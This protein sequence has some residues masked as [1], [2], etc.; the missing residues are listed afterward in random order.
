VAL[1]P[2][3]LSRALLGAPDSAG[4]AGASLRNV[5]NAVAGQLLPVELTWDGGLA[6]SFD[7]QLARPGLAYQLGLGGT[8]AFR[9]IQDDTAASTIRRAGFQARSGLRLS[10]DAAIEVAY[11]HRDNTLAGANAVQSAQLDRT[12]PDVELRWQNI[13]IPHAIQP[14][15][16]SASAVAGYTLDRQSTTIG[17]GGQQVEQSLR[18]S[19]VPLQLRMRFGNGLSITYNSTLTSG[20]GSDPT[21]GTLQS[22]VSHS[23]S[24]GGRFVAPEALRDRFP[25]PIGLSV[26]YDYEAERQCRL[27]SVYQG[28]ED[29]TP[30]VDSL[31]RRLDVTLDS[32]VSQLD[33][34]IQLSYNDRRSFVGTRAGNSQFQLSVFGQFDF[35]AGT[36]AG[37]RPGGR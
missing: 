1:E 33:V 26:R 36:F 17:I 29:C 3:G 19:T 9:T 16:T 4:A 22:A 18:Q 24:V 32:W 25:Q 2:G 20:D 11:S 6:S 27:P 10:A 15:L 7:R 23:L 28:I 12:W 13:T 35:S 37:G 30:Y 8:D 5:V 14:F 31:N 21:G 34:G